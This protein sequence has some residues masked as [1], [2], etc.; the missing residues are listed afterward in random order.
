LATLPGFLY[1]NDIFYSMKN[2]SHLIKISKN[3]WFFRSIY[4]CR[5]KIYKRRI[6]SLCH[7]INHIFSFLCLQFPLRGAVAPLY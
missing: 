1:D 4:L 7:V 2:T 5:E 3:I 6:I